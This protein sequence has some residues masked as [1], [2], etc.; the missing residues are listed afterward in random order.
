MSGN[1]Y[2]VGIGIHRYGRTEGMT[3]LDMG[4][5]AV[6]TALAD[7]GL[8]WNDVQFAYGGSHA[9]GN[10]DTMVARLGLTGIQFVNVKNGCA[11]GGSESNN[12][13]MRW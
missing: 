13:I 7:A 10:A 4:V 2:I 11:T 5:A 3:G 6:R 9:A 1:V 12:H 8:A